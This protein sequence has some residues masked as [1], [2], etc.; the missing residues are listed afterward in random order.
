MFADDRRYGILHVYEY[1]FYCKRTPESTF[2]VSKAF[3]N[4]ATSP[5]VLQGIK[6][7]VGF[8]DYILVGGVIYPKSASK[9]ATKSKKARMTRLTPSLHVTKGKNLAASLY[10]WNCEVYDATDNILLM[11]TSNYPSLLVKMQQNPRKRHVLE[12]MTHEAEVYAALRDNE[13]VQEA[14]VA[15]HGHSTH[16]GV[17][18]TCIEREMDDLDDIGLEHVSEALKC[19]AVHAVSLLSDAGLLHNDLELR[20]IVQSKDDPDRAKI[21]DF[22][23]AVFTSDQHLLA[24]QVERIK[25]LLGVQ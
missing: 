5:S 1:F 22:G 18:M 24:E 25:S 11:T 2:M 16:L 23:R 3:H 14:V 15:F 7:M 10:P 19:S 21:I 8:S 20:N 6:T 9:A 4:T 13:A 12:E 17:A